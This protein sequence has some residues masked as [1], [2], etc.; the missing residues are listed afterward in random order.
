MR[1]APPGSPDVPVMCWLWTPGD[2][3]DQGIEAGL[4]MSVT[5]IG[6]R[7]PRVY[8]ENRPVSTSR[9]GESV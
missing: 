3:W 9:T 4:D 7:V 1:C 2:P 8:L 6:A 5:R